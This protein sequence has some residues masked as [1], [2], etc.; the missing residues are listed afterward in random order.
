MC[1][2]QISKAHITYFIMQKK[3]KCEGETKIFNYTEG[4]EFLL[5]CIFQMLIE[6][7]LVFTHFKYS[8]CCKFLC[9]LLFGIMENNEDGI[10]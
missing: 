6:K 3:S 1:L 7:T 10:H 5:K 9:I 8:K 4:E 2:A